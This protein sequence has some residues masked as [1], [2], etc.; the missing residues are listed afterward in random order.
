VKCWWRSRKRGSSFVKMP[1][2]L[3]LPGILGIPTIMWL[4]CQCGQ[5]NA[6]VERLT[7]LC[8]TL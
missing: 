5:V 2:Q 1:E 3:V 4:W 7:R 8:V 6:P